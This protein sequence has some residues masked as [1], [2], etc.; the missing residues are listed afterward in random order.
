[1]NW[2][3]SIWGVSFLLLGTSVAFDLGHGE[4]TS[5]HPGGCS[6][7]PRHYCPKTQILVSEANVPDIQASCQS[8]VSFINNT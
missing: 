4:N 6:G 2:R 5:A 7:P 8:I 1:M 3:H